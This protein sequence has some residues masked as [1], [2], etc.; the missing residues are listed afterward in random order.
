[1]DEEEKYAERDEPAEDSESEGHSFLQWL[2]RILIPHIYRLMVRTQE[3][4]VRWNL[5]P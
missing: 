3:S 5:R 2:R 4:P 1:M